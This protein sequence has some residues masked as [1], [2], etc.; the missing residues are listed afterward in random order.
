VIMGNNKLV[1]ARD[2]LGILDGLVYLFVDCP[3]RFVTLYF[4]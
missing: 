4:A 1:E 3:G 2:G